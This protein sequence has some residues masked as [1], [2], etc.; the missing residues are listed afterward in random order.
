MTLFEPLLDPKGVGRKRQKQIEIQ[1]G[2]LQPLLN[3]VFAS[4]LVPGTS[5]VSIKAVDASEAD[6]IRFVLSPNSLPGAAQ[7]SAAVDAE[8]HGAATVERCHE[9]IEP[10]D[11]V[12]MPAQT[13]TLRVYVVIELDQRILASRLPRSCDSWCRLGMWA[14]ALLLM[15]WIFYMVIVAPSTPDA[16][17]SDGH[18][19]GG[20][21]AT[22]GGGSG[23]GAG[24]GSGGSRNPLEIGSTMH[25][26][27]AAGGKR[28]QQQQ[29]QQLTQ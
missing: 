11:G 16:S 1:R 9:L 8:W 3:S 4:S 13:E 24:V 22:G 17:V 10:E 2:R 29:Q 7:L 28:Q 14:V 5:S 12:G 19:G 21:S 20:L 25:W 6:A 23:G 26:S 27:I 15:L 18:D